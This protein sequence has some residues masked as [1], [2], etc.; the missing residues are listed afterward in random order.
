MPNTA[1]AKKRLRQNEVRRLQNRSIKTA[2]RTQ[3]K[4]VRVAVRA[5]ELEKAETEFRLAAKKLDRAGA[6]GIL[7]RNTSSRYKSRLQQLIKKAK[8][9]TTAT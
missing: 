9:E 4:K 2:V 1:S 8:A 3:M 6:R 5:G 7:H